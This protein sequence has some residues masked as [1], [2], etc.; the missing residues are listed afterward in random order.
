MEH[1]DL[2][3]VHEANLKLLKEIDRICRKYKIKYMID[4]GTLLGAVRHQGFIPWDDDADVIFTRPNYEKFLKVAGRELPEGM[5]LLRP[6]DIRGGKVFYDF[7]TRIIY[8]NSRVHEDNE[9]MQFYEGKLN[10]IWVD[11]FIIDRLPESRFG[12]FFAKFFR[13]WCTAWPLPTGIGSTFPSTAWQTKSGWERCPQPGGWFHAGAV[14][15][16][17]SPGGQGQEQTDRKTL[18]QQL[19]AGFSLCDAGR[20]LVRKDGGSAL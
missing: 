2:T 19:S 14:P 12:A 6:E 8:D 20:G 15:P 9:Q 4:S 17:D 10:H 5:T 18:L 16:S 1:W 3:K 13:R 7:T 11:L